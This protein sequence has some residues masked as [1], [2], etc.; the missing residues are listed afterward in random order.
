M[1]NVS[2]LLIKYLKKFLYLDH[3]EHGMVSKS[4]YYFLIAK[5]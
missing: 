1:Q 3:F 2:V 5:E 4:I